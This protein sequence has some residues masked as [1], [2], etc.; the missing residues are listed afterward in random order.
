LG[1]AM[2]LQLAACLPLK[3]AQEPL[4]NVDRYDDLRNLNH[5]NIPTR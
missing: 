2:A 4:A 3:L 5:S 1:E